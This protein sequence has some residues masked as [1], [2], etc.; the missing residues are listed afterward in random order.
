MGNKRMEKIEAR[1]SKISGKG[2]FATTD[3]KKKEI[4]CIMNGRRIS[5]P[6]LKKAYSSG[7]ARID[8]PFQIG[9]KSYMILNKPYNYF[10]HSCSPNA[11]IKGKSTMFALRKIEKGEE[12]TFDYS[13]TEWTNDAAWKINW[14]KLWK[15]KCKCGSK[16]CRKWVRIF[17]LL[18]KK[19]KIKYKRVGALPDFILNKIQKKQLVS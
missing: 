2:V 14:T 11:G 6:E 7:K 3:I 17:P 5:I 18:P 12:I 10:N 8:D 13:T 4:I 15:I 1:K 16:H 19:L 9:D